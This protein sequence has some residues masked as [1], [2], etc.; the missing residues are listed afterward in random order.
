VT[1]RRGTTSKDYSV[2]VEDG[3]KQAAIVGR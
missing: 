3:N 1:V 2:P